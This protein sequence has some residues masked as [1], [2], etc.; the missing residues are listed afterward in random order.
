MDVL[1]LGKESDFV[2]VV[3]HELRLSMGLSEVDL[4]A[5]VEFLSRLVCEA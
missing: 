5:A 3:T 4:T 2:R 1:T